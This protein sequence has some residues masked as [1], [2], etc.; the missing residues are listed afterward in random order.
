[1]ASARVGSPI[2]SIQFSMGTW[3]EG[4]GNRKVRCGGGCTKPEKTHRP[5][6][7][8]KESRNPLGLQL[9]DIVGAEGGT[10]RSYLISICYNILGV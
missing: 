1:M 8:K 2:C 10:C 5:A 3:G 4:R 9:H 7:E 6:Y